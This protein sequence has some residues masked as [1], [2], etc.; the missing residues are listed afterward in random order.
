M[1]MVK[2]PFNG[3]L[4]SN[5]IFSAIFNMIISQ[6]VRDPKLA[7]NYNSLVGK[8]KTDGSMFG[9]TKLFYDVDVLGTRPWLGDTEASNLLNINRPDAPKCQAI[10]LDTFRQVDITIDEYLTKRAW[11]TE[12]A[13]SQ[14]NSIILKMLGK[15]KEIHETTLFNSYIGSIVTA[16]NKATVNVDLSGITATG[17]EK[18]RLYAQTIA[19]ELADLIDDM[20]DYSRDYNDYKFLRAYNESDLMV[21]WNNKW[22]NKL[23]KLDLPTVYH[24]SSV[25]GAFG[26]KLPA[27]YFGDALDTATKIA[28]ISA[29]TPTTGKPIDSDTGVYTPGVA[30]ANGKVCSLIEKDVTV[31]VTAYHVL[32]G[33]EIPAGCVVKVAGVTTFDFQEGEIY[34]PDENIIC[35]VVSKDAIKFMD[36]FETATEFFNPRSLT[37]NHYLTFG[38]AKPDYLRGEAIVTVK[39]KLS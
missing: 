10:T 3:N 24:D 25:F 16:A 37:Q 23:T 18:N 33:D 15:A 14:F 27:R 1:A 21:V 8:F 30:N 7:S 17:E 26:D 19:D 29:S 32:P 22:V 11:S 36:A 35:K 2:V 4:N 34:V 39:A 13:F 28:A 9:D 12:G 5:E 31:G 38:Y 20:M 6:D